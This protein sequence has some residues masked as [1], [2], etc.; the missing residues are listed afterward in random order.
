MS[1]LPLRIF[2]KT[3][4][5]V[6]A[7]VLTF[8]Y[9]NYEVSAKEYDPRRDSYVFF[10]VDNGDMKIALSFDDGPHPTKTDKILDILEKYNVKATFFMVGSQAEYCPETA[11]RVAELGH[12]IGNHTQNHK[13]LAKLTEAELD[14][15]LSLAENAITEACGY[16]PSLFRPP[17]GVCT[18]KIADAANAVRTEVNTKLTVVDGKIADINAEIQKEYQNAIG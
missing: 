7:V 4:V 16:I 13:S 3:S 5:F 17:E 8:V 1:L 2:R 9:V 11:K 6:L 18:E 10:K 12:E 15:E 14:V